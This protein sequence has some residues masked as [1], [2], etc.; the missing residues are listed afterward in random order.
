MAVGRFVRCPSCGAL[1]RLGSSSCEAC[2]APLEERV[3]PEGS[4]DALAEVEGLQAGMRWWFH[5]G[6]AL[7]AAWMAVP[8]LTR[9]SHFG[10]LDYAILPF[11]EAGHY[12]L[13]PFAPEFLVAAGGTLVQ[14]GL[15]LGFA[16][17]FLL[18]R[19][20]PF[21][22]CV[23]AFWLCASVQGM[24]VYMKDARFLLLP[25]FGADPLDGHDWN[26]LFG[27]VGLL[28]RSVQIG[29]FFQAAGR[30]GMLAVLAGMGAWLVRHRPTRPS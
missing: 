16:L 25:M 4:A 10:I 23:A 19:R 11:H 14:L 12:F 5:L 1:N 9:P 28:H 3:S 13:M 20:E 17:Y 27:K 30:V 15:P 7:L 18:V 26:Y 21:A 24:A 22:A 6:V 2:R 29:S 8:Y